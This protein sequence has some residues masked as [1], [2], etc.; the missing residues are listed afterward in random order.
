L[1]ITRCARNFV[2][3]AGAV[4]VLTFFSISAHA[5]TDE[6]TGDAKSAEEA[7]PK[8]PKYGWEGSFNFG[9][10]VTTGNSNTTTGNTSIETKL[11]LPKSITQLG[12]SA[13]LGKT[14][15]EE[16]ADKSNAY[17]QFNY[18]LTERLT[19]YIKGSWERD[20]I[21][22]LVWRFTVGP[23]LGYFFIKKPD[24]SLLGEMG[25]SYIR[26]NFERV[27]PTDYYALR[28]AE[29]GEWKITKTARVWEKAEYL[30]DISEF[31]KRFILN[32]EAGIEASIST[33]T[34]LR[35]LVQDTYNSRPAPGRNRN[36]TLYIAGL[37]YKF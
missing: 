29:Q 6:S 8:E 27:S 28:I 7:K 20:R 17:A 10:T 16:T 36:D 19:P 23:G 14:G 31:D 30:P 32:G 21:A 3:A 13:T 5:Q 9:L 37:G 18:L 15:S 1:A 33:R 35:L 2:W 11:T 34:T 26:E 12:A 4:L 24:S 22:D 25:V